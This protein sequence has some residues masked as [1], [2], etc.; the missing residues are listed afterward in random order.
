MMHY[1]MREKYNSTRSC[2]NAQRRNE[3]VSHTIERGPDLLCRSKIPGT[4]T[5]IEVRKTLCSICGNQCG[6]DA[7]VKDGC[8]IKVEGTRRKPDKQGNSLFK[9]PVKPAICL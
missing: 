6:I 5:G 7:Y 9:G 1:N 4:Q 2:S 8:V 3:S